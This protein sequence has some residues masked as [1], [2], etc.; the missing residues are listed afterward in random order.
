MKKS[1]LAAMVMGV[2]MA[3]PVCAWDDNDNIAERQRQQREINQLR[4]DQEDMQAKM[5]RDRDEMEYKMRQQ[6]Y[7]MEQERQRQRGP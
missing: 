2:L 7:E 1:V 6:Q 5:R 4:S 3:G